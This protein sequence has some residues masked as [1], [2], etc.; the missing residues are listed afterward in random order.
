ML[1]VAALGICPA[2]IKTRGVAMQT[3][4]HGQRVITVEERS[5]LLELQTPVFTPTSNISEFTS[6]PTQLTLAFIISLVSSQHQRHSTCK[7]NFHAQTLPSLHSKD[8]HHVL[9]SASLQLF[10]LTIFFKLFRF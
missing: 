6:F 1:E 5:Q 7:M 9:L 8:L 3:N 4:L 2:F 10:L